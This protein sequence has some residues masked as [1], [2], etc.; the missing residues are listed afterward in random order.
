MSKT[1]SQT[2]SSV[3]K[4]GRRPTE[5]TEEQQHPPDPE[6]VP[7]SRRRVHSLPYKLNV[8]KA[9]AALRSEG[10]GEIGAYLRREG[11]YYATVRS[12]ER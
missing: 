7:R 8:L 12:W 5:V 9:V 11:L 3:T 1:P 6:V 4:G 2:S 10:N